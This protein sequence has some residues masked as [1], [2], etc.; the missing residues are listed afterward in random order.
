MLMCTEVGL[1]GAIYVLH[2]WT[3][4]SAT[5]SLD[6]AR[7]VV[8]AVLMARHWATHPE[9]LPSAS[10]R[11]DNAIT[12]PT[13]FSILFTAIAKLGTM[14]EMREVQAQAVYLMV[15]FLKDLLEQVCQIT[16]KRVDVGQDRRRSNR[17]KQQANSEAP[18][19]VQDAS[20]ERLCRTVQHALQ[21]MRVSRK[22]DEAIRDGYMCFLLRRIG[23]VLNAFVFGE[24][25]E[26]WKSSSTQVEAEVK[27]RPKQN[28]TR[29]EQKTVQE[30]QAPYL[31]W[32]LEQSVVCFANENG[33]R[34]SKRLSSKAAKSLPVKG[35]IPLSTK[36][37]L[38]LQ[39]MILK[40]VMGQDVTEFVESLK[41]PED[42]S[43]KI[44]SWPTLK[45]MNI[46][47]FFKSE[48]WRLVGWD[49]LRD[50]LK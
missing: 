38:Q 39:S 22:T 7:T 42:P 5:A 4:S 3:S 34:F 21:S 37:K 46:V 1:T 48:V 14:S 11:P 50:H 10:E 47:D 49:C 29:Q 25:D 33:A 15:E 44:E 17:S 16:A 35:K 40:E 28:V 12:G 9:A 20:L 8:S 6:I 26:K 36:V 13:V 18:N 43:I 23:K 27:P 45:Q 24:D 19:T 31:I 30:A 32:L 2:K 41:E